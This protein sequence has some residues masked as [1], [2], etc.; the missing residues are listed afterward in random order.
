M[1]TQVDQNNCTK[2]LFYFYPSNLTMPLFYCPNITTKLVTQ[3]ILRKSFAFIILL[4][5]FIFKIK[6]HKM[7]Y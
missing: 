4:S 1:N 2:N 3:Y 7:K 5:I 6:T